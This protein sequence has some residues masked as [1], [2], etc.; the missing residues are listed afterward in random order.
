MFNLFLENVHFYF[1]TFIHSALLRILG[2]MLLTI[3]HDLSNSTILRNSYQMCSMKRGVFRNF[4]KFTGTHLCQSP[5]FSKVEGLR[6]ATLLKK[7]LWHRCVPMNLANF[8]RIPFLENTSGR[9]LNLNETGY[10]GSIIQWVKGT[11]CSISALVMTSFRCLYRRFRT[12][13]TPF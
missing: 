8:L 6:S 5:F 2:D 11:Q 9:L 1:N 10:E 13:V 12:N 3:Q 4:S 7:R